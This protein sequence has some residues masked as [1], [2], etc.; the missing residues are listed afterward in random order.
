MYKLHIV[1]FLNILAAYEF[2]FVFTLLVS[3]LFI[4]RLMP[5]DIFMLSD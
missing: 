1:F 5:I 2:Q 4:I 3:L